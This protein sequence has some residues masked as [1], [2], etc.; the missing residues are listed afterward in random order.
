MGVYDEAFYLKAAVPTENSLVH[1]RKP[2]ERKE[3]E[4]R[5]YFLYIPFC[6]SSTSSSVSSFFPLELPENFLFVLD[7]VLGSRQLYLEFPSKIR[8]KRMKNRSHQ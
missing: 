2:N 4:G 5:P 3:R 1:K 6:V 7:S 8:E